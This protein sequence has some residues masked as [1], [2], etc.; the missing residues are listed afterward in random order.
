MKD[1]TRAAL[2]LWDNFYVIVGSSGAVLTGLQFVVIALIAESRQAAS[3]DTIEAFGSPTIVHFSAVLVVASVLSAPWSSL[4]TPAVLLVIGGI[5]GCGYITRA[6]MIARRQSG[7][8]PVLE[9][10]IFH[11]ILPFGG[12]AALVEAGATLNATPNPLSS[13]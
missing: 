7:Y 12:Y 3:Q 6:F 1:V 8:E 4:Y 2:G 11:N 10:W 5:A 9:D 13:W